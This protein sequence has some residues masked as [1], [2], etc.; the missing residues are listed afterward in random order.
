MRFKRMMT[1]ERKAEEVR[2][3]RGELSALGLRGES[4][5][6]LLYYYNM[7]QSMN[8]LNEVCVKTKGPVTRLDW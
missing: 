1:L 4:V 2:V 6:G 3:S 8:Q 7:A 5:E